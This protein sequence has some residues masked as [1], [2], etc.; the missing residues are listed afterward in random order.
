M[1]SERRWERREG[2]R[3]A[4]AKAEKGRN[5]MGAGKE[6][7]REIE[8]VGRSGVH[9]DH[10]LLQTPTKLRPLT[11]GH[12]PGCTISC[13]PPLRLC[14]L[15]PPTSP[16]TTTACTLEPQVPSE[17]LRRD[18]H[19]TP[20]PISR[21][22]EIR[23]ACHSQLGWGSCPPLPCTWGLSRTLSDGEGPVDRLLLP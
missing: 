16:S 14:C 18:Q 20:C 23:T 13:C 7:G 19:H 10:V 2:E 17:S 3:R 21:P 4:R 1:D 12:L 11:P 5:G 6:Q 15:Q 8:D 9:L 22:A